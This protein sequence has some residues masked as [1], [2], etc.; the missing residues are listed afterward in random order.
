MGVTIP[1]AGGRG[2]TSLGLATWPGLGL[3]LFRSLQ[4]EQLCQNFDFAE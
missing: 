2:A 1:F 4:A 3:L